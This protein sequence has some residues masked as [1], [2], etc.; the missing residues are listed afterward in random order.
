MVVGGSQWPRRRWGFQASSQLMN[1]IINDGDARRA[2]HLTHNRQCN[3]GLFILTKK[4]IQ[5]T[6]EGKTCTCF[7]QMLS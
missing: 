1:S 4:S 6:R 5:F 3:C 2:R 7:V